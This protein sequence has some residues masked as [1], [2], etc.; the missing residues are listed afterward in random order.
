MPANLERIMT[1]LP[2]G[3]LEM[4]RENYAALDIETAR[5]VYAAMR[6]IVRYTMGKDAADDA[7]S[8]A[9]APPTVDYDPP[10]DWIMAVRSVTCRC[11]RCRGTGTYYW[12]ACI[13]GVMSKSAPCARCG[14]KGWMD[15]DDM[16]RGRAYDNHAISRACS[17]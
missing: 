13:N 3:Y 14:G 6:D 9:Y 17:M 8:A 12:G 16:R 7:I 1:I 4:S 10:V 11:E 15:F 2:K 5:A